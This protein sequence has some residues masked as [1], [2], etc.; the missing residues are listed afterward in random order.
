MFVPTRPIPIPSEPPRLTLYNAIVSSSYT[1]SLGV[2]FYALAGSESAGTYLRILE[3]ARGPPK[4]VPSVGEKKGPRQL[5][6]D[7]GHQSGSRI[8]IYPNKSCVTAQANPKGSLM[9]HND[10][11][12]KAEGADDVI[13]TGIE[14]I[15]SIIGEIIN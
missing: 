7:Q 6:A 15:D 5:V 14:I 2:F 13:E 10:P 1:P 4:T 3:N 9:K 11:D 12:P 8:L